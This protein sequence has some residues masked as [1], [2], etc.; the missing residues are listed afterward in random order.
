[1]SRK[2]PVPGRN[3][4]EIILS[5]LDENAGDIFKFVMAALPSTETGILEHRLMAARELLAEESDPARAVALKIFIARIHSRKGDFHLVPPEVSEIA[6]DASVSAQARALAWRLLGEVHQANADHAACETAYKR[7]VALC[8]PEDSELRAAISNMLGQCYYYQARYKDA[9]DCFESYKCAVEK[10]G[11]LNSLSVSYNNIAISH[12][13]LGNAAEA[14]N[15]YKK[16]LDIEKKNLNYNNIAVALSNLAGL[17]INEQRFDAAL[18]YADRTFEFLKNV[19]NVYILTATLIIKTDALF[20]LGR[21]EE[22][23]KIGEQAVFFAKNNQ[24]KYLNPG[25][26]LVHGKVLAALGKPGAKELFAES[27][28]LF[29]EFLPGGA[30]E[31]FEFSLFEHG[32]LLIAE[33][34]PEG[35]GLITEALAI[36]KTR[37]RWP[38]TLDAIAEAEKL[39]ASAPD[40]LKKK[41]AEKKRKG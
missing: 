37:G 1:M 15:T 20:G 9:L 11:D 24:R 41:F 14:E 32:K 7:A 6:V 13:A 8:G 4:R 10:A 33:G 17:M 35:Y 16:L 19:E 22:A 28:R 27:V 3:Y 2:V 39:L 29:R 30:P 34:D 18:S 25:A 12:T 23:E 36:L 40:D 5:A 26:I 31:D 21:L 38:R